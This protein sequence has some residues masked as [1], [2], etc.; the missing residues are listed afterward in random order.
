M[1]ICAQSPLNFSA[2]LQKL[3]KQCIFSGHTTSPNVRFEVFTAVTVKITVFQDIMS[4]SFYRGTNIS[5]EPTGSIFCPEDGSSRFL[6]SPD[7]YLPLK[8]DKFS[9]QMTKH[10]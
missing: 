2:S 6:H 9:P 3:K 5:E 8:L 4:F 10:Y 7:T 1:L